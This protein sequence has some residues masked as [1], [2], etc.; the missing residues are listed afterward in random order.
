MDDGKIIELFFERSER[1]IIEL[2]NKYDSIFRR[3]ANNILNNASDAEE[4]VNEA[5]LGVWNSIPPQK[6]EL[7]SSY[8]CRIVRNVALKK[9]HSDK[10][11]KRNGVYDVVLDEI[12]ECFSSSVSVEDEICAAE[13]SRVIDKF[14]ETLDK[15][16]R[17]MFIK[18]YWFSDSVENIAKSFDKSSHYVSVRLSR[19]RGKLKKYL[20]K[21]GLFI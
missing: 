21:E 16:D 10:A 12:E 15:R 19:I 6:P 2:S 14:L 11:V 18:R 1:A 3:V 7:L 5:Y 20:I 17:V 8:V 13:T 4:C 9:Y